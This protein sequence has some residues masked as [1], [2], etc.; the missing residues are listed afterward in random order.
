MKIK[1]ETNDKI[2]P[3]HIHCTFTYCILKYFCGQNLF[4][5]LLTHFACVTYLYIL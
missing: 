3:Q 2:E 1:F 4:S 5:V